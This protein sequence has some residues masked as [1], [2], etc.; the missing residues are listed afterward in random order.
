MN[1]LSWEG[2]FPATCYIW[3]N[4]TVGKE[5]KQ[6]KKA[7]SSLIQLKLDA[8]GSMYYTK[9]KSSKTWAWSDGSTFLSP[10]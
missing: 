7:S 9:T 4:N 1:N 10:A 5:Q 2:S 8:Y 6:N 3:L